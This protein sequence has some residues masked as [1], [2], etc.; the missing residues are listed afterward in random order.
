MSDMT[1]AIKLQAIAE[2]LQNISDMTAELGKL[3]AQGDTPI[4]DATVP[5]REGATQTSSAMSALSASIGKVVVAGAGL[6][7]LAAHLKA[8]AMEAMA[9]DTRFR[10]LEGVIRATGGAAGFTADQVRA[11]SSELALATLGNEQGFEDAAAALMTFKSVSGD[12]FGLA[13]ELSQDL[14]S[15]MGGDAKSAAM[16]LGRALEDPVRGLGALRRSGVSFTEAQYDQIKA[17]ME[18]G[19]VAQ[20]HAM[21]LEVVAGQVGGVAR[22]MAGGLAGALDTLNQRSDDLRQKLGDAFQPGLITITNGIAEAVEGLSN[23]LD[24]VATLATVV[25]AGA[26]AAFAAQAAP[27][28]KVFAAQVV[29]ATAALGG[30]RAAIA[31]MPTSIKIG[32]VVAGAALLPEIGRLIGETAAKYGEAGDIAKET[33]ARLYRANQE[34]HASG[35][36]LAEANRRNR[37]IVAMTAGE[38]ARLSDAEREAYRERLQGAMDY[39]RGALRAAAASETLGIKSEFSAKQATAAMA[40][41]REAVADFE[42]GAT[43]SAEAVKELVSVDASIFISQFDAI[44]KEGKEADEAIKGMM[45]NF[46]PAS[47]ASV[48]GMGQALNQLAADGKIGA[49]QVG[50]AWQA[51][52]ASMSG[53]ELQRFAITAQA[54]FTDSARDVAALATVMDAVLRKAIADTGQDFTLLTTGMSAD[55]TQAVAMLD[56]M[57]GSM[58]AMQA[59]GV[60][61]AAAIEGALVNA[62]AKASNSAD[63]AAVTAKMRELG[64]EGEQAGRRLD[65]ALRDAQRRIEDLEPGVQSLNEAFRVLGMKTPQEL[66]RIA[67]EAGEAFVLIRD[68]GQATAAQ[69]QDAFVRYAEAAIAANGGVADAMIKVRAEMLGLTVQTTEAGDKIVVAADA[70]RALSTAMGGAANQAERYVQALSSA[71]PAL[72]TPSPPITPEAGARVGMLVHTR[73]SIIEA[74]KRYGVEMERAIKLSKEFTDAHGNVPWINNPGQAKYAGRGWDSTLN[75]AIHNLAMR[76][77]DSRPSKQQ[78]QEQQQRRQTAINLTIPGAKDPVPVFTDPHHADLLVQQLRNS[79]AVTHR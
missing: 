14:A 6:G 40:K 53:E 70:A 73:G 52:L 23:N 12:A 61:T 20:A 77:L 58:E 64:L 36:A 72:A 42:A 54:A 34:M 78:Q 29:A 17:M 1:V 10:K 69:L 71:P 48:Q 4:P 56:V 39:Q 30:M 21:I 2:G 5:L 28:V 24:T 49:E 11:M 65:I 19:D 26:V 32:L 47:L 8:A 45:E 50:Q 27:A 79:G 60:N 51:T 46:K 59:A 75:T 44:T 9:D 22:E 67:S 43:M 68:S 62:L 7:L 57:V 15:V 76:E 13:L 37:D 16:Q 35:L 55:A 41:L 33:A 38:V 3:H 25:G 31:A 63:V 74:L 18:A 66:R